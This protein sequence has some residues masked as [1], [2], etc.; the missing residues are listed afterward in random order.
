MSEYQLRLMAELGIEP[1]NT[2]K[3]V[4]TLEDKEKYVVYYKNL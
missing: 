2:E 3:L 4:L 1:P